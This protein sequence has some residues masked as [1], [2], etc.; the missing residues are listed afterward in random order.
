MM[1]SRVPRTPANITAVR[2]TT[3]E[4]RAPKISRESTSRPSW[5]VPSRYFTLPPV[6]QN[7]GLKRAARLPTSG[8]WG[9]S[10]LAKIATS[11]IAIRIRVG[12]NGKSP[13]RKETRRHRNRAATAMASAWVLIDRP[14]PFQPD[15]GVDHGVKN[16]DQQI[17]HYDHG[18]S[19]HDDALHDW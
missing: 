19:Q 18:A 10:T 14:L 16:V 15:A 9:A 2:P 4:I 1:P 6:C 12:I 11:A 5:S 17:H 13:S 7:G 8:L 3:I